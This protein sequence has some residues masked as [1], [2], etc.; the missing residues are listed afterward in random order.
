[1]TKNYDEWFN[2]ADYDLETAHFLFGGGR[3][4]YAV[5]YCHLSIEKMLK[6]V[7]VK[8][9]LISHQNLTIYYSS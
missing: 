4:F 6:G 9:S 3:Y 8:K 1:V 2:Q 7:W 5:F